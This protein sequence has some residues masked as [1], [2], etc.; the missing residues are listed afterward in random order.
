M[1][2]KT[3]GLAAMAVVMAGLHGVA[4]ADVSAHAS[5]TGLGYRLFDLRPDDGIAPAISFDLDYSR[6]LQRAVAIEGH[7]PNGEPL[8]RGQVWKELSWVAP[9]QFFPQERRA[10]ET[11]N[12]AASARMGGSLLDGSYALVA[13][14]HAHNTLD[15]P[16]FVS[17]FAASSVASDS[18][19]VSSN[20]RAFSLTPFT[21]VIWSAHVSLDAATTLG[22]RGGRFEEASA[23]VL[24]EVYDAARQPVDL[25]QRTLSVPAYRPKHLSERWDIELGFVNVGT[26]VSYGFVNTGVNVAGN[27]FLPVPE[28][29]TAWLM[30]C[31]LGVVGGALRRR[32]GRGHPQQG[33]RA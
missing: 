8:L 14:G 9:F 10:V 17:R 22:K 2:S 20:V 31:G 32:A 5:I 21:Q 23:S 27:A 15:D 16:D 19:Q 24:M 11:P 13:E 26:A 6:A 30:L 25:F 1:P 28:T 12:A 29:G 3:L 18:S 4:W 7:V 33:G